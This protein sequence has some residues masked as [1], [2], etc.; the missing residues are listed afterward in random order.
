MAQA[1]CEVCALM[2]H[3]TCDRCGYSFRPGVDGR[4]TVFGVDLCTECETSGVAS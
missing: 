4:V 2:G 1:D 3:R